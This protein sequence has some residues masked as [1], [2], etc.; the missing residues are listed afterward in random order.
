MDDPFRTALNEFQ[1]RLE[2]PRLSTGYPELDALIGGIEGGGFY[3]FYSDEEEGFADQLLHV[4]LVNSLKPR[5][6]GGL[7][8]KALYVNCGNYKRT[9]TMLDIDLL[10]GLIKAAGLDVTSALRRIYT[11]CAFSEDQQIRAVEAVEELLG[12]DRDIRLVAVQQ[13][14]KLFSPPLFR[15][16]REV[17]GAFQRM[18][19]KLRQ[20]CAEHHVALVATC[21]P[22]KRRVGR[23][24][25]PEGGNYLRHGAGVIVYFRSAGGEG[26]VA[27]AYLLKHPERG[28]TACDIDFGK[29]GVGLGRVTKSVRERLQEEMERLK[30]SYREALKDP[31]RQRAFDELWR[32]WASEEG[33]M[34][35]S[36]VP[37]AL[38]VLLLTAVVDNRREIEALRREVSGRDGEAC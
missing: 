5:G 1:A 33:A 28:L 16:D 2:G 4:L 8:G 38:D 23:V 18:V 36:G 6:E 3:L 15:K 21:R 12:R 30:R 26:S 19:S 27:K 9:R 22:G 31:E 32:A 17:R 10:T 25:W 37:T 11:L 24:R 34:I 13:I 7:G 20:V 35:N 14:A 29:G